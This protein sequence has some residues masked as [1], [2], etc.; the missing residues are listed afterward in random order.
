MNTT[1]SNHADVYVSQVKYDD[2]GNHI[3]WFRIH[4]PFSGNIGPVVNDVSRGEMI[5]LI[6]NENKIIATAIRDE[7]G[8]YS[9]GRT[10]HLFELDSLKFLRTDGN[11]TR[12]DNLGDL[13]I[14]ENLMRGHSTL[15]F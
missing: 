8:K 3:E 14:I 12:S 4:L 7:M 6:E 13:P 2:T 10:V 15:K 5:N 11:Q 9:P 1:E